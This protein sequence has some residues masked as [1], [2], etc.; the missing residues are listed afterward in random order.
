MVHPLFSGYSLQ[1]V[2][3]FESLTICPLHNKLVIKHFFGSVY[4]EN[5][6]EMCLCYVDASAAFVQK[7]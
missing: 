6:S 4:T 5:Q 3:V 2:I 7:K 1:S